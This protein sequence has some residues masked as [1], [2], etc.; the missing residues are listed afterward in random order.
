MLWR[1]SDGERTGSFDSGETHVLLV[2]RER[3]RP[4]RKLE[5]RSDDGRLLG[6][7]DTVVKRPSKKRASQRDARPRRR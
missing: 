5:L 3:G 4:V 6:P 2:D 7:D 1:F